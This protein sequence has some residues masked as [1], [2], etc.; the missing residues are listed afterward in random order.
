MSLR[1]PDLEGA[2][3]TETKLKFSERSVD[4]KKAF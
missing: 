1:N 2:Y 3:S 4:R